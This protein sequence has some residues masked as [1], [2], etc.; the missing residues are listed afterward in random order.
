MTGVNKKVVKAI[1][2]HLKQ[3][4]VVEAMI[5]LQSGVSTHKTKP[6]L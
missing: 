1:C 3:Y 5:R 4:I 2:L 6:T